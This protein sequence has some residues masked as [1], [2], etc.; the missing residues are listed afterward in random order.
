MKRPSMY[1]PAL[2]L[3]LSLTA[4]GEPTA[5]VGATIMPVADVPIENGVLVIEDGR[6]VAV[7]A[8]GDIRVPRD[9]AVIDVAVRVIVP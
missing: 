7:G 4:N 3:L 2:L 5:F 1:L 9:A 6:I 8:S